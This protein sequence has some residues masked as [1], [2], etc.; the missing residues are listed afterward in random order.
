VRRNPRRRA[1]IPSRLESGRADRNPAHGD[2]ARS[3]PFNVADRR[4]HNFGAAQCRAEP[5]QQHGAVASGE[6][7]GPPGWWG[8]GG[9]PA[10]GPARRAR[11]GWP[12]GGRGSPGRL[13]SAP[14]ACSSSRSHSRPRAAH[15][16]A[17]RC[18]G[19]RLNHPLIFHESFQCGRIAYPAI[20]RLPSLGGTTRTACRCSDVA[21]P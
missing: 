4:R 16:A 2:S 3:R 5:E 11:R 9:R 20:T 6:G 10:A 14:E 15:R 8:S 12:G 18:P 7:R 17:G 1:E 13:R 19:P 21:S